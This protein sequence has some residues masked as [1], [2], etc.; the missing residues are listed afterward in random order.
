MRKAAWGKIRRVGVLAHRLA[1][2]AKMAG[3]YAHPTPVAATKMQR[4]KDAKKPRSP[5]QNY[6]FLGTLGDLA[7]LAQCVGG[8]V[9]S[10]TG[11]GRC[12][13]WWASTLTLRS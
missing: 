11:L 9:Y 5:R 4:A 7:V 2:A 1:H 8:R 3:D 13:K 12:E 6:F 10:P